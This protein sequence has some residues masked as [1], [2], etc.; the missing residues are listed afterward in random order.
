VENN[1]FV[2]QFKDSGIG[3]NDQTMKMID[4]VLEHDVLGMNPEEQD[5]AQGFML[6]L[7]SSSKTLQFLN[8]EAQSRSLVIVSQ[9]NF[10]TTVSM[11]I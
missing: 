6:G 9:P 10:G 7:R 4:M 11:V 2:I 1:Y 3:I 8:Q 5:H